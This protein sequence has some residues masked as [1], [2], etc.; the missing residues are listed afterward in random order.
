MRGDIHNQP[1]LPGGLTLIEKMGITTE[2]TKEE[3][4]DFFLS[5]KNATSLLQ[6]AGQS[7]SQGS[8][9]VSET[10]S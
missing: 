3:S 4:T 10:S 2:D 9:C 1:M 7:C 6:C 8:P 5:T